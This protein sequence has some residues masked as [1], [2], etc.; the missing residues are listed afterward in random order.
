MSLFPPAVN[1]VIAFR[2]L[3]QHPRNVRRIILQVAIQ[4][5]DGISRRM[6]DSRAHRGGLTIVAAE[7]DDLY[8]MVGAGQPLQF[9]V[10]PIARTIIHKNHF[11]GGR[12]RIEDRCQPFVHQRNVQ[13][14]VVDR[15][16]CGNARDRRRGRIEPPQGCDR[17]GSFGNGLERT[18]GFFPSGTFAFQAIEPETNGCGTENCQSREVSNSRTDECI[19]KEVRSGLHP[20]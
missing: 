20:L 5:D 13:F 8:S 16:D 2:E 9:A 18:W 10:R 12:Q 7:G 19:A 14:L 3:L 1:Q 4:K 17:S 6:A 11:P 15:D